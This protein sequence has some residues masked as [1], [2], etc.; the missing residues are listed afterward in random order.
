MKA[1]QLL[2]DEGQSL[3]LDNITRELVNS[4][5]L[6]QYID[7]L[8][9]TGLTSNPT[10]FDHAIKN[11]TSYDS[12]IAEKSQ[13]GKSGEALFFDLALEDL[14]RAADLFRPIHEKTNGVDGWVSLEVSPLLAYDT[15]ST[16]A[17]AKELFARA[18]RPNLLIKIPGTKQGLPAIEEAIFAGVP[19]NVTLLF[20]REQY[21]AAA[22]AFLRGIERRI[23]AGLNPYVGSV[24]SVFISR[25]DVAVANKVPEKL[26]NQLGIAI[27]KRTY[28][29]ASALLSSPRWQRI[30]NLG[31]RPQRLLWA[32]TGS[33]DP[34]ASDI[35]YVKALAAPFTVNTM[36]EATLKAL[37]THT[38]LGELLPVDGGNSEE[39][40]REF[41]QAGVDVDALAA[42]LQQEGAESFVKS[43]QDL[44]TVISSKTASL[45]KSGTLKA[46]S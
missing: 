37:A 19:I 44:M 41:A 9:V 13:K 30:Y 21:V 40:L 16:L 31:G 1:T 10:I 5:T 8:S 34:K 39:M 22:E 2:H 4:G 35:L 18:N 29:A 20:S 7:E 25:W 38:E 23:Q 14:T 26:R 12:A 28:K 42:E 11:S 45:G 6:K 17:A 33:K 15:T 3:W 24:A 43:W 46:V 27:A 36:P 32:S